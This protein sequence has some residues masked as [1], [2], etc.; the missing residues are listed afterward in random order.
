MFVS[1]HL[2]GI[3]SYFRSDL[4]PIPD[5]FQLT[6]VDI[7]NCNEPRIQGLIGESGEGELCH[8][9]DGDCSSVTSQVGPP[10]A[11]R[12]PL[13]M[14]IAGVSALSTTA[15]TIRSMDGGNVCPSVT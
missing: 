1:Q 5:A 8:Q 14:F 9:M 7:C 15:I 11:S 4:S 3:S 10:T 13:V 2:F 12:D 6:C